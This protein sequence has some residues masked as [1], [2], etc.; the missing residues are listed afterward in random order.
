MLLPTLSSFVCLPLNFLLSDKFHPCWYLN[1][2]FPLIRLN[3]LQSVSSWSFFWSPQPGFWPLAVTY[4]QEF[5]TFFYPKSHI[6]WWT[7]SFCI[8]SSSCS[9]YDFITSFLTFLLSLCLPLRPSQTLC[10]LTTCQ[11]FLCTDSGQ[12]PLFFEK[13][14][15]KIRILILSHLP[16]L[17]SL[18]TVVSMAAARGPMSMAPSLDTT[19]LPTELLQLPAR[20]CTIFLI[21]GWSDLFFVVRLDNISVI[22]LNVT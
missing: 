1:F 4:H 10:H 12:L 19:E 17:S 14:G 3:L 5:S 22:T 18:E 2:A 13:A 11:I 8:S 21:L 9:I 6:C 20:C 16:V 7:A 15:K